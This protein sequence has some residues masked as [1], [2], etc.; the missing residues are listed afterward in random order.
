M[1]HTNSYIKNSKHFV[2]ELKTWKLD[3]DDLLVSFDVKSLFTSVPIEDAMFIL[4]ERLK[5]DETMSSVHILCIP[6]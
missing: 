3:K 1:G 5:A 6:G 2:E 4:E